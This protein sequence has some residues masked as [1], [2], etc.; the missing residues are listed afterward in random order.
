MHKLS[1]YLD[2]PIDFESKYPWAVRSAMGLPIP[3]W[4]RP[5]VW[6]GDQKARFITSIWVRADIGTYMYNDFEYHSNKTDMLPFS[7][8]LIDGQHRLTAIEE[9]LSDQIAV[10][11]ASGIKRVWSELSKVER[12]Y[13]RSTNFPAIM[14]RC[15]DEQKLR[16]IYDQRAFSGV[17]H[18]SSQ[19]ASVSLA[20]GS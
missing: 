18:E 11:D 10:P 4:Q 15:F 20:P 19:R 6:T 14:I 5:L 16:E 1:D 3:A 17:P 8:A 12:R 2:D 7:D 9:Y 13:F